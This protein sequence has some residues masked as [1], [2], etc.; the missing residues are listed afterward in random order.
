MNISISVMYF[1]HH[2][3]EDPLFLILIRHFSKLFVC[4]HIGCDEHVLPQL[5]YATTFAINH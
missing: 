3:L 5:N 1:I 2:G 4:Q